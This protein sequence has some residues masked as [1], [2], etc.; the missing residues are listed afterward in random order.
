VKQKLKK[1]R[2][3]PYLTLEV[4]FKREHPQSCLYQGLSAEQFLSQAYLR[5]QRL[6]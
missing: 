6:S 1:C 2:P 4:D 5:L 3:I